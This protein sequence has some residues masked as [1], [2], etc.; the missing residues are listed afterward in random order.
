METKAKTYE[1]SL[2]GFKAYLSDSKATDR[3]AFR[4]CKEWFDDGK[5]KKE[6]VG[7]WLAGMVNSSAPLSFVTVAL[8][9][10]GPVR[11]RSAMSDSLLKRLSEAGDPRVPY[12]TERSDASVST[13]SYLT[14]IVHDAAPQLALG[15]SSHI[16]REV[17]HYMKRPSLV[18]DKVWHFFHRIPSGSMYVA[19]AVTVAYWD[20]MK[21]Q[22][23]SNGQ[24]TLGHIGA[25]GVQN[26]NDGIV[27]QP[28]R[29]IA[30]SGSRSRTAGDMI[31]CL[32]S[33]FDS[34]QSQPPVSPDTPKEYLPRTAF[35]VIA[36]LFDARSAA[37]QHVP[38]FRSEEADQ[39]QRYLDN[40]SRL[41]D[42]SHD[43]AVAVSEKC[44]RG[45]EAVLE[46]C[47]REG[48]VIIPSLGAL[49]HTGV[50][51]TFETEAEFAKTAVNARK[52]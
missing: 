4:Y 2:S 39:A 20:S 44:L 36:K 1:T 3:E 38:T 50:K 37:Q 28:E 42:I 47:L 6:E 30:A 45:Q 11:A 33:Y 22:L 35:H 16:D 32:A 10:L 41:T 40:L 48:E 5:L 8:E 7:D 51:L 46:Q 15:I 31:E 26:D 12:L 14:A 21:K 23:E 27:F 52:P 24:A 9:T 18:W 29:A 25:L 43:V 17:A 34:Q 49:R 19:T 13:L